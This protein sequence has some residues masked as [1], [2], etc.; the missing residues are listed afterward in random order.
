MIRWPDPWP[1]S[2][3]HVARAMIVAQDHDLLRPFAVGAMRMAFTEGVDLGDLDAVLECGERAGL[4]RAQLERSLRD[5]GVKARLRAANED[6]LAAGV[7]GV[8]TVVVG[9]RI[10]WGDDRLQEAA[11][12]ASAS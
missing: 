8:P 5:A 11:A 1:T 9:H 10:F 4:D 12:A 2:D 6:A 3:V 7:T